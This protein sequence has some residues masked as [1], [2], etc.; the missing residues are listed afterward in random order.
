[1]NADRKIGYISLTFH[2]CLLI[3]FAPMSFD[4]VQVLVMHLGDL[5]R[6]PM[7]SVATADE[8]KLV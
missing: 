6:I 3:V 5:L 7:A 8:S 4:L 1:M 2:N